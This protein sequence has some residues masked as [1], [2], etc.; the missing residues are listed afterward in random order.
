[1]LGDPL[2]QRDQIGQRLFLSPLEHILSPSGGPQ[3]FE[4]RTRNFLAP[5]CPARSD[6]YQSPEEW[7]FTAGRV[8]NGV[9]IQSLRKSV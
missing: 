5:Q 7:M 9:F 3:A 8:V 2:N 1:L 4:K 6:T